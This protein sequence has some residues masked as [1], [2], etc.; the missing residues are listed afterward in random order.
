LK[1]IVL[2]ESW[3]GGAVSAENGEGWL[4]P[5]RLDARE[6]PLYWS[7]RLIEHSWTGAGVRVRFATDSTAIGLRVEPIDD[8]RRFDLVSDGVLLAT[9]KLPAEENEITFAGLP[10][11]SR[12]LEVWLPQRKPTTLRALLVAEGSTAEPAD[13]PRPRWTAY[14]SSITHGGEAHSPARTWPGTAA[15]EHNLNLTCLGFGGECHIDPIVGQLIAD[16]PA[17]LITLKLGI[18][19]HGASSLNARTLGPAVI[20]L[21]RTIR[22]KQPDVPVG[23]ISPIV[24]PPRETEP[25]TAGLS[26]EMM[27]EQIAEAVRRL[28]DAGDERLIYFDGRELF[29]R[30][31]ADAGLLP[32]D[33]H[34]N[35]DGYE[36]LGAN[37]ARVV[38]PRLLG[39][40]G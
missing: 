9:A 17:D 16:R 35:G 6:L 25:N 18:N 1:S 24:S 10:Q 40:R 38:I 29:S 2:S 8:V 27:R 36:V 22:R 4:R 3:L 30:T 19:V 34:P 20:G 33:L 13:D 7:D 15:R 32:D 31:E 5:C 23:V 39:L 11:G 21:V 12:T 26:L 14:G 37:A 28:A